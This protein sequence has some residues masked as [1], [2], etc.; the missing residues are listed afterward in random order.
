MQQSEQLFIQVIDTI[1]HRMENPGDYKSHKKHY[2]YEH[3]ADDM[4]AR[5]CRTVRGKSITAS[6]IRKWK[7]DCD[8]LSES[9]D[10][11]QNYYPDFLEDSLPK[12]IWDHASTDSWNEP[13]TPSKS[14]QK[15]ERFTYAIIGKML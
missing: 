15:L 7:S 9:E 3:L 6:N 11:R 14:E 1:I 13:D 8:K 4:N 12:T 10:F 5:G 2:S